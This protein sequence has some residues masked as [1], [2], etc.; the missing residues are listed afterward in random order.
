MQ[1]HVL[2]VRKFSVRTNSQYN[3]EKQQVRMSVEMSSFPE[4]Y[5]FISNNR[6][7]VSSKIWSI[8]KNS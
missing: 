3:D 5:V 8:R 2:D 4:K 6:R 7:F 1:E